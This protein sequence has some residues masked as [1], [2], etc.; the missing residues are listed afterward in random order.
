MK[1]VLIYILLFCILI[2]A[3]LGS[4]IYVSNTIYVTETF[5]QNALIFQ[6]K[7]NNQQAAAEVHNAAEHWKRCQS[8]FGMLLKHEEIDTVEGEFS[9]LQ[10]Y[11][12]SK[13]QDDFR[14]NCAS[15][16]STLQ[17]IREMEWPYWE[18]IF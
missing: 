15:L 18:N 16:L 12:N 3:C 10:A 8:W 11:V 9:S 4:A 14:S 1:Y 7:G 2:S 13:D 17:H 6:E 5:L